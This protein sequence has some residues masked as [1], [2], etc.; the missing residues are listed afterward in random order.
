MSRYRTE[1]QVHSL[2]LN[3]CRSNCRKVVVVFVSQDNKQNIL[4]GGLVAARPPCA[5]QRHGGR[6]ATP[7]G[8]AENR[9]EAEEVGVFPGE[10]TAHNVLSSAG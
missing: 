5:A 8:S 4:T 9:K 6:M 2:L 1:V 7:R 3:V 10:T